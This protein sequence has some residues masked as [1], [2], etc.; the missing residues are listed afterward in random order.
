MSAQDSQAGVWTQQPS[1]TANQMSTK[2][3]E[4]VEG[5][6]KWKNIREQRRAEQGLPVEEVEVE[7]AKKEEKEKRA[8][9]KA[10]CWLCCFHCSTCC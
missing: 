4:I 10:A 5:M 1:S 6:E 3:Q 8:S 9:D 2:D 7:D